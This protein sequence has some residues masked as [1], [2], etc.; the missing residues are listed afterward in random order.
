MNENEIER[1]AMME[2]ERWCLDRLAAGWRYGERR[3]DIRKLH[4]ALCDWS[5]LPPD[6]RERNHD[7]VREVPLILSD[8][9]F[10]LVRI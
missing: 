1:L 8:A 9:G 10:Q 4:P 5:N 3:D 7:A 6:I 2:H